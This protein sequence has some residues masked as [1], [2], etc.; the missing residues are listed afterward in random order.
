VETDLEAS[1]MRDILMQEGIY[2]FARNN[3]LPFTN[4][5]MSFFNR[6]GKVTIIVNKEDLEKA[7]KIIKEL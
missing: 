6:K 5:I 1:I 4:V 2:S 3:T 7:G